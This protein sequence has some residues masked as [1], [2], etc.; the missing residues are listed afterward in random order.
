MARF[1]PTYLGIW[2]C[3]LKLLILGIEIREQKDQNNFNAHKFGHFLLL[4]VELLRR[5]S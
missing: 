4:K 2:I 3:T 5:S 1:L